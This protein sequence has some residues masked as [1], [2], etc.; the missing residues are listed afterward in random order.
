MAARHQQ[1]FVD[2]RATAIGIGTRE[3]QR[4]ATDLDQ[5]IAR[6]IGDRCRDA[7]ADARIGIDRGLR[8]RGRRHDK[9]PRRSAAVVGHQVVAIGRELQRVEALRAL[10]RHRARRGA[11]V[12]AEH[13][14]RAHPCSRCRVRRC[15]VDPGAGEAGPDA[16]RATAPELQRLARALHRQVD[17]AALAG[18][19]LMPDHREASPRAADLL[20]IELAGERA[21]VLE[22]PVPTRRRCARPQRTAQSEIPPHLHQVIAD[23]PHGTGLAQLEDAGGAAAQRERAADGQ[24]AR[25]AARRQRAAAGDIHTA[26]DAAHAAER[27]AINLHIA[28]DGTVHRQRACVDVDRPAVREAVPGKYQRARAGLGQR[29]RSAEDAA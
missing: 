19:Q 18:V 9:A 28:A 3:R 5:R 25:A 17:L 26:I 13:G 15:I 20:R 11:R 23:A 21:R 2:L 7:D 24:G 14:H 16:T 1:A 12:A 4:P 8:T 27:A 6:P 22:Q 10:H 29:T